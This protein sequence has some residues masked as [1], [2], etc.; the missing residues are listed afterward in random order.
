MSNVPFLDLRAIN[1][2]DAKELKAN[3]MQD[4]V[5]KFRRIE[6]GD[7]EGDGSLRRRAQELF[8][9]EQHGRTQPLAESK[10]SNILM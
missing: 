1:A 9:A 3:G 8:A 7:A 2:R 4:G 5:K 6:M 10:V